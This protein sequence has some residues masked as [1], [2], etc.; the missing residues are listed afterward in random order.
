VSKEVYF[1]ATIMHYFMT[2][3]LESNCYFNIFS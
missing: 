1:E 3:S 2:F